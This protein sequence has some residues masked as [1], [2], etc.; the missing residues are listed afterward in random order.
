VTGP[1]YNTATDGPV[2]SS[3]FA[4]S[5]A[6]P[7]GTSWQITLTG[8][9]TL[10]VTDLED[11]GDQFQLYDNGVLMSAAASP[12]TAAGQNPGQ[13]S[14][15]SGNTSSPSNGGYADE[16]INSALGNADF[17][18]ATF[19]L[20]SG[21]NDFTINYEGSLGGGDMAFI[22][23]SATTPEPSSLV[24]FGT[25]LVGLLFAFRRKLTA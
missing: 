22:A 2:L 23:E 9:G 11:S 6:A 4:N 25:G 21:V 14:P 17:S 16:D 5:I 24:L 7:S 20:S 15:G 3:G 18:S 8:S 13:T 12:F 10:T 1:P 19:A